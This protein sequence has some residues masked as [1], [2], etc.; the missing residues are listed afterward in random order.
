[1]HLYNYILDMPVKFW[2]SRFSILPGEL[3]SASEEGDRQELPELLAARSQMEVR[4]TGLVLP[5]V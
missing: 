1:M 3:W 2:A 5:A 4:T